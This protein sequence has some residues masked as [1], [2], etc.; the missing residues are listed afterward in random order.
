[1]TNR[2]IELRAQ[3]SNGTQAFPPGYKFDLDDTP[4]KFLT[5]LRKTAKVTPQVFCGDIA[6]LL[7]GD[8]ECE[9]PKTFEELKGKS[10][11]ELKL[12]ASKLK[13]KGWATCSKVNTLLVKLQGYYDSIEVV[14]E[15]DTVTDE[16]KEG[17]GE[18]GEET[19][20]VAVVKL[21]DIKIIEEGDD[22]ITIEATKEILSHFPELK[23][24]KV[25]DSFELEKEEFDEKFKPNITEDEVKTK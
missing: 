8:T 16:V 13:I 3:L 25:G 2:I 11:E 5:F 21:E 12:I 9:V 1:M 7:F 17:G 24:V 15:D 23:D 14:K 22:M 18:E 10:V 19:G 4:K 20:E 6:A